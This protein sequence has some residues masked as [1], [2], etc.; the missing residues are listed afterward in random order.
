MINI[1]TCNDNVLELHVK[2]NLE[3]Y[4]TYIIYMHYSVY[5]KL[6]AARISAD[7]YANL[8]SLAQFIVNKLRATDSNISTD[9]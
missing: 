8:Q 9:K 4:M 1:F 7:I 2:V 5:S 3:K 6:L